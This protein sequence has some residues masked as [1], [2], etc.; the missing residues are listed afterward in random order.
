MKQP[1]PQPQVDHHRQPGNERKTGDCDKRYSR[2][3]DRNRSE[4]RVPSSF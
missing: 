1:W 2:T 3:P 4:H